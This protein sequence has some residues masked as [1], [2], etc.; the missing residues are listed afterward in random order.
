MS[1]KHVN[2]S[3]ML[4]YINWRM[5]VT[6]NDKR[7]LI[8]TFIA[9]D[10]HMNI[11][12]S[13]TDEYRQLKHNNKKRK[14]YDINQPDVKPNEQKRTVGLVLIRGENVIS[15]AVES[16]PLPKPKSETL[17]STGIGSAQPITRG[18]LSATAAGSVVQP[19]HNNVLQQAPPPPGTQRFGAP[20]QPPPG[21]V[22]FGQPAPFG[23][24]LPVCINVIH[25]NLYFVYNNILIYVFCIFVDL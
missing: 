19:Q 8:G 15:L 4:H 1:S 25:Q 3:K 13:D 16:P 14:L 24:A 5:R 21:T 11:V 17:S 22:P 7:T 6:L 12:L 9:Y 10:K 2:G 18:I 23:R 20:V